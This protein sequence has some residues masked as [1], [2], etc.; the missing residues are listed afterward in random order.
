MSGLTADAR[1]LIDH[2]RVEA[3]VLCSLVA[4]RCKNSLCVSLRVAHDGSTDVRRCCRTIA[5]N[6]TSR[7]WLSHAHKPSAT[8]RF[9]S[10]RTGAIATRKP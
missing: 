6:T 8:S 10:A 3:Q 7:C 2:A 5:S 1:T 4:V 9:S